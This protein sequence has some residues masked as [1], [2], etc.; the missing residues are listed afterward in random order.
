MAK[1][2]EV[3]WSNLDAL[4]EELRTL[5]QELIGEANAILLE[6]AQSAKAAISA[7]YPEKTGNLKRGLVLRPARGRT[8]AGAILRQRAPHGWIYEHGTKKRKNFAGQ[9]RGRMPARP[10]FWPIAEVHQTAAVAAIVARL[11]EHGAAEVT[12]A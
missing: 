4:Y 9:N 7:A 12:A 6:S 8:F 1:R 3:S 5:P 11:H 2:L 10:T